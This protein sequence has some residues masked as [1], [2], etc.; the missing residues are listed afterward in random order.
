MFKR[1]LENS[2]TSP[3]SAKRM[4]I[5]EEMSHERKLDELPLNIRTQLIHIWDNAKIWRDL[6]KVMG[7]ED[8]HIKVIP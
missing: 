6:A 1:S 8:H 3:P 5:T 4:K 7:Y 2:D